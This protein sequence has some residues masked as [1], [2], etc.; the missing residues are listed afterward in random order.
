MAIKFE[1]TEKIGVLS[2]NKS[3]WAKE[4]NMV[5]W[6]DKAAKLDL[7]D[8]SPGHDKMG[9]GVTMTDDEAKKLMELLARRF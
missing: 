2:T 4:L 5:S 1:I 7:R 9:K 3:G 8:W 6:N